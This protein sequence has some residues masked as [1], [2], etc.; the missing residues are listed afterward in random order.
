MWLPV[1][2]KNT[3]IN[4]IKFAVRND[5]L[6][7]SHSLAGILCRLHQTKKTPIPRNTMYFKELVIFFF[8]QIGKLLVGQVR[9]VTANSC[10]CNKLLLIYKIRLSISRTPFKKAA[11]TATFLVGFLLLIMGCKVMASHIST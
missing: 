2:I 1:R 8:M 6:N 5:T 9:Y 4:K 3:G 7:S 10:C 11:I